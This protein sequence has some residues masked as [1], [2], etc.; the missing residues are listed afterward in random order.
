MSHFVDLR[1]YTDALAALRD[2]KTID[3]PVSVDLEAA[4]VTR[5]S[6]ELRTAAPLFTEIVEDRIGMRLFGAP[7]GMSSRPDIPLARLALSVGLPPETGAAA[8]VEHLV[9][10]RIAPPVPPRLVPRESATCKQNILL[11]S[12]ASL[13]HFAVPRIHESDGGRYLNTWGVI[14]ARM[15]DRSWTNWSIS[16]IMM[17]DGKRMTGLVVPPQPLGLV[18]Q[19]WAER[20]E[21]MPYAL[22][23]GGAPAIPFVGGIPLPKG[24]DEAG[25]IGALH[26]EPLDVVR[27]ETVDLEVPAHAEVVIEGHLSVGRDSLEGPFGEYAGYCS[28]QTSPQPVYSVDAIT[29]RD[30]PIWPVVAEGRPVDEYHTVT[31]TGRSA[32]VLHG[33]RG[34]GLPVTTVWM[35]F[36]AAMHWAVVTVPE[37]WRTILPD[38]DSAEF[39]RRIGEVI[40]NSGDPSN[41]MPT[42]FVLDDDI[43]PSDEADL[44]WALATRIHPR[45]RRLAW[46]STVLPLMACYT[47]EE[48]R[49]MRGPSVVHDGLLPAWGEGRLS[50]SSFAQAYPADIRDKVVDH[51]DD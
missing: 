16:R 33:L 25:Y 35:P 45:D 4:A 17:L 30:E 15:P 50:H 46:D 40:H 38:V 28:N 41:L 20:G 43:D 42:T 6:Y 11:G 5:R 7:A 39:V 1:E 3:R 24:V 13:D 37:D 26:G 2:L 48:R 9:R 29:Y 49:R 12:E 47:E 27:C 14:I 34:A 18:W 21:P 32:N 31:G 23:Q 8:L 36:P 19:A 51:W 22:V 44:L 10:T